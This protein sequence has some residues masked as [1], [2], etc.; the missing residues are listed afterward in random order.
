MGCHIGVKVSYRRI[1]ASA[2]WVQGVVETG[3]LKAAKYFNEVYA[4][5]SSRLNSAGHSPKEVAA[6]P[7]LP[8][9]DQYQ[10]RVAG[11]ARVPGLNWECAC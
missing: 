6:L 11:G 8:P 1:V 7:R 4:L 3:R 10:E 5:F 9:R 2:R